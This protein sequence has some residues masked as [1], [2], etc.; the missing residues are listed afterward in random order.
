MIKIDQFGYETYT[1]L[2]TGRE[3][4]PEQHKVN[5][6]SSESIGSSQNSYIRVWKSFCFEWEILVYVI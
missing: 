5:A 6:H 4:L 3:L 1:I 2:I